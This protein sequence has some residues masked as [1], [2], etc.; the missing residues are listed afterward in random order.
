M[1]SIKH[2]VSQVFRNIIVQEHV[3][4]PELCYQICCPSISLAVKKR[5][6]VVSFR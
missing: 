3:M 2:F 1:K 5:T 6:I 4:G